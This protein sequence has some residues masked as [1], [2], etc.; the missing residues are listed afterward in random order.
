[1]VQNEEF[2]MTPIVRSH[3]RVLPKREPTPDTPE[4]RADRK[5]TVLEALASLKETIED[6][7]YAFP[8]GKMAYYDD[9]VKEVESSQLGNMTVE[10]LD[11]IIKALRV[12]VDMIYE[13]SD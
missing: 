1:M 11:T 13:N 5:E 3:A 9:M 10:K 6:H 12:S 4:N 8:E 2:T 7:R